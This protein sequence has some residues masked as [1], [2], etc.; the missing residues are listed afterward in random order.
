MKNPDLNKSKSIFPT[1]ALGCIFACLVLVSLL[2]GCKTAYVPTSLTGGY[3]VF[4]IDRYTHRIT[5]NA[6]R[7]T[8]INQAEEMALLKAS[9][10][11]IK[12][13]HRR[14]I[15]TANALR[16]KSVATSTPSYLA[17]LF[18]AMPNSGRPS[19]DITIRILPPDDPAYARGLD[20]VQI[21]K[22]LK[23]KFTKDGP[24]F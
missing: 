15:V 11:T 17:P 16:N 10:I 5:V 24:R 23:P 14:F 8:K 18:S 1:R 21:Y 6:N 7:F 19:G 4:P 2:S 12:A 3:S 9:E 22:Y 13:R 20:A